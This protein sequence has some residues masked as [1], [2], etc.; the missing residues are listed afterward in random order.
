MEQTVIRYGL[1]GVRVRENTV[2]FNDVEPPV[3]EKSVPV[4]NDDGDGNRRSGI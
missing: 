3:E 1:T 2:I 4:E